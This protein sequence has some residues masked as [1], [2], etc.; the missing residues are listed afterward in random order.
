MAEKKI[1][2]AEI[3]KQK[4][5]KYLISI[6]DGE[7][8]ERNLFDNMDEVEIYLYQHGHIKYD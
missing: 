6:F 1:Q 3:C 8:W 7:S 5:G 4:D 2:L